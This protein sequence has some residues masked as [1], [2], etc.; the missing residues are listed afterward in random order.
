MDAETDNYEIANVNYAHFETSLLEIRL[1]S[2]VLVVDFVMLN[3]TQSMY[4]GLHSST[5]IKRLVNTGVQH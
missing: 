5:T 3:N 1:E 2:I 4:C